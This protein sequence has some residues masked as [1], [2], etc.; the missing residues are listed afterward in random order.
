MFHSALHRLKPF[1]SS[2]I[3]AIFLITFA[4]TNIV[5]AAQEY[6]FRRWSTTHGLSNGFVR[7]IELDSQGFLWIGT[8]EG[9]N[10]FDG[11][12][13]KI[14]QYNPA[15]TTGLSDSGIRALL[16]T[17]DGS[18]WIGTNSAG[19]NRLDRRTMQFTHYRND[20]GNPESLSENQTR[21]LFEDSTGNLWI[22]TNRGGLNKLDIQT[23]VITRFPR[24][25]EETSLL[26]QKDVRSMARGTGDTF[27][28]ATNTGIYHVDPPNNSMRNYA[29][30]ATDARSI[31]SDNVLSIC[32]DRENRL[33]IG[34]DVGLDLF[35]PATETFKH[36][37]K[38]SGNS[39]SITDIRVAEIYQDSNGQHWIGTREMGLLAFDPETELF[40]G[41]QNDPNNDRS[42]SNN[43]ILDIEEDRTGNLWLGTNQKGLNSTNL[44][45]QPI[46]VNPVLNYSVRALANE[47]D[48]IIWIGTLDGGVFRW[49][50]TEDRMIQYKTNAYDPGSIGDNT[51]ESLLVDN[52]G[53]LW[54]GTRRNGL[55][56]YDAATNQFARYPTGIVNASALTDWD[57]VIA[58]DEDRLGRLWLISETAGLLQFDQQSETYVEA[59][60]PQKALMQSQMKCMLIDRNQD[61]VLWIGTLQQGLC[62]LD[63]ATGDARFLSYSPGD[64][65]SISHNSVVGVFQDRQGRIWIGTDGGGLNLLLSDGQSFKRFTTSDG[66]VSNAIKNIFEDD[67]GRLWINTLKGLCW[68]DRQDF[69]IV[70]LGG[71]KDN[72]ANAYTQ[73]AF[74]RMDDGRVFFGGVLG[75]SYFD[76]DEMQSDLFVPEVAFT[77][78]QVDGQSIIPGISDLLPKDIA[79]VQSLVLP[80]SENDFAFEFAALHFTHPEKNQYAYILHGYDTEWRYPGNRR[81]AAYTNIP[82]GEY[83]FQVKASNPDGVWNEGGRI[84]S[85][86]VV[87]PFWFTW[88]FY[89]AASLSILGAIV[90]THKLRTKW[91]HDRNAVLQ[92]EI[93]ERKQVE[94]ALRESQ[95]FNET[96]LDTSPDII[97][98]YDIVEGKNIYS[99]SGV[100]KILGFSPQEIQEMGGQLIQ[101]LMHPDDFP[102]YV[103]KTIPRYQL[104]QNN[105]FIEH[106]YRMKHKQGEWRWLHSKESV[107][108]RLEDG[109]PKQIFGI[110]QNITEQ[111]QAAEELKAARDFSENLVETANT[112]IVTLDTNAEIASFNECAERLTGY[113]K[114]EV[115]G[116][117][118]FDIF[119]PLRD[120]ENIPRV[121]SDV[122]TSMPEVS[123]HENPIVIKNGDERIINWSNSVLHDASGNVYGILSIGIDITD[124]VLA[125]EEREKLEAQLQQSQKMESIGR[126]AG[127]IA[128]DFNNILAGMLGNAEL[129]DMEMTESAPQ[130]KESTGM[131]I[132]G[133]E[134]AAT[135]TQQLLGFARGGRYNPKPLQINDVIQDVVKVSGKIFEKSITVQYNFEHNLSEIDADKNQMH[136]VLTNLIINA[137][138]AMPKGGRIAISTQRVVLDDELVLKYPE[139]L[140]GKYVQI[141]VMDSGSG[142]APEI[143][144][145]IFEPFFTTKP[146][147][148]GT[149]L[150]LAM[151]YGIVKNHRGHINCYSEPGEGTTFTLY[152]PVSE[153]EAEKEGEEEYTPIAGTA[154]VL[155]VD[156]EEPV[157][158]AMRQQLKALGYH[159][160]VAESG[161]QALQIYQRDIE[162]IDLVLL[163]MIMPD[164]NGTETFVELKAV[165]A[166]IKVLLV[167]GYSQDD[168]MNALINDGA[169]G[170]IQKPFR[171]YDISKALNRALQ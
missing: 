152:L 60:A 16:E 156:D 92:H 95:I 117:N 82:P 11:Y 158:F 153:K 148:Q 133:I 66:L 51:V 121:F 170:F 52:A 142:M 119:I 2:L 17:R 63:I 91:L 108:L 131:I 159:V 127:G 41:Y 4:T 93:T 39:E 125:D 129:L 56:R 136:Q 32:M 138:D 149:G 6:E 49:D 57:N 89:M 47:G 35:E 113:T 81:Y 46:K 111:K 38:I 14:F 167:S 163:D 21:S 155:I 103:N 97:Y 8:D 23:G 19:L 29:H 12:K 98:V 84:I 162:K 104:V 106:E 58:M 166:D 77:D 54:I 30:D 160:M 122:L 141:D 168:R 36:Y 100:E 99:N 70:V 13:F 10:R 88:W 18:L 53:I 94:H 130:A 74:C 86:V 109:T 73:R 71:D 1:V 62:R 151:V 157:R 137:R 134:R 147:G 154:T 132:T 102:I 61:D 164:M 5:I 165:D 24:G 143:Q 116:K 28:I 118:W 123:Q 43:Y 72:V 55:N 7:C 26:R 80:F 22:G 75:V 146:E 78:F 67:A 145:H 27:W 33:W 34:G 79:Q 85:V 68:M 126:L 150:G 65:S 107:F 40:T 90:V 128:H 161:Q 64:A 20:P 169:V 48:G 9:L 140:P 42:L 114:E 3:P 87:P 44:Y 59:N 112:I 124:R 69:Q 120:K 110:I 139:V 105:E 96:I 31:S 45:Q 50:F 115:I 101:T 25:L 135:L 37:H 171:I 83:R 144:K 15:D 76:P